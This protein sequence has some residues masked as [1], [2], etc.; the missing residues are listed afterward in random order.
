MTNISDKLDIH[1]DQRLEAFEALQTSTFRGER[2][3]EAWAWKTRHEERLPVI[4]CLMGGTG[5]GKS[6]IFNSLAGSPISP[7]G[8]RRPCTMQ[9]VVYVHESVWDPVTE[10]PLTRPHVNDREGQVRPEVTVVRHSRPECRGL[11]LVDTPDFDSVELVNRL[12]ADHFFVLSDV[13]ILVTSQEKYGDLAGHQV[14]QD[15]RKWGKRTLLVM[16]KAVS[17]AAF[18]DFRKAIARA[19]I[20]LDEPVRIERKDPFPQMLPD[21]KDS[22]D[23]TALAAMGIDPKD[24]DHIR[25]E[26]RERLLLQTKMKLEELEKS[27]STQVERISEVN[28]KI[29]GILDRAT[30]SLDARL[31]AVVTKAVEQRLQERLRQ[32]LRKYDIFFTPRMMIRSLFS[33]AFRSV[34][35]TLWSEPAQERPEELEKEVR[36]ED[37]RATRASV[38]LEPLEKSVAELNKAVAELLAS[39]TAL[40]DLCRIAQKDVPRWGPEEIQSQFDEAFPGVEKLLEKEF[41]RFRQGL[42]RSDEIKLYSAYTFWALLL[43][44]AES[45]LWGGFT[46]L[47]ALLSTILLPLIPKWLLNLKVVDMLRAIGARVDQEYRNALRHILALQAELYTQE[48]TAL[49]PHEDARDRL[50]RLI[51]DLP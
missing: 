27:L 39:D 18:E 15:A 46:L 28:L 9:A 7:V 12:I 50:N 16:N 41:E 32:L 51:Q 42:S 43:I 23:F 21:L 37:F 49:L 17:D 31:D 26:E 29:A 4:V 25:A 22:R 47:D 36:W 40:D 24:G 5:T 35:G 44:C 45:V 34:A 8:I 10:R 30:Q 3:L 6:T 38:R 33:R 14:M 1:F 11:V 13:L 19:G 48:F 2:L 20:S